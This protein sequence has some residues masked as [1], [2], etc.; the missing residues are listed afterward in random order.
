[1]MI[2]NTVTTRA[3]AIRP[4]VRNFI[5]LLTITKTAATNRRIPNG[6]TTAC[7]DCMAHLYSGLR[8]PIPGNLSTLI[9]ASCFAVNKDLGGIARHCAVPRLLVIRAQTV[10]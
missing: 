7:E 9:L 1:M 2:N 8:L 6:P 10:V 3:I 5:E 4:R